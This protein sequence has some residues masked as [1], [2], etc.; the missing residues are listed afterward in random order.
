MGGLPKRAG[1]FFCRFRGVAAVVAVVSGVVLADLP[2]RSI[3]LMPCQRGVRKRCCPSGPSASLHPPTPYGAVPPAYGRGWPGSFRT[4]P[5][6]TMH[7]HYLLHTTPLQGCTYRL[8]LTAAGGQGPSGQHRLRTC[9]STTSFTPPPLQGCT[10]RLPLT[11][12]G[13]QGPSGQHRLRPC[14]SAPSP[15]PDGAVPLP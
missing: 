7:I 1:L 9:I 5:L 4:T 3:P 8:P 13:G 2:L 10:Y 11:A 6:A 12:A 15:T 14:T